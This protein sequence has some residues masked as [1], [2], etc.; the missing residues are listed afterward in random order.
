MI[1]ENQ[2]PQK[3]YSVQ[4]EG[5]KKKEVKQDKMLDSAVYGCMSCYYMRGDWYIL[6]H[7]V[8]RDELYNSH[9]IHMQLNTLSDSTES[10]KL[11]MFVFFNVACS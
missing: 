9:Y 4:E 3:D 8:E 2:R 5:A 10:L 1:S 6:W 7:K 11:I